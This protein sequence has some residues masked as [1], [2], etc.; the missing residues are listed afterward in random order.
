MSEDRLPVAQPPPS[1]PDLS[2]GCEG[3]NENARS[4][5]RKSIANEA[6]R[7]PFCGPPMHE[8]KL[9]CLSNRHRQRTTLLLFFLRSVPRQTL[10]PQPAPAQLAP[11]LLGTYVAVGQYIRS[12]SANLGTHM[13]LHQA[14]PAHTDT[15]T[16]PPQPPPGRSLGSQGKKSHPKLPNRSSRLSA[17]ARGRPTDPCCQGGPRDGVLRGYVTNGRVQGRRLCP[18]RRAVR[19]TTAHS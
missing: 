7:G 15:L 3:R 19:P 18:P 5:P 4:N 10:P 11:P 8:F 9:V 16:S 14:R 13:A 17:R 1:A 12:K 2:I 6:R